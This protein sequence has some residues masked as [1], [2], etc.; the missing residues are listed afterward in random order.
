[1]SQQEL[2]G[3][4][5]VSQPMISIWENG[6]AEPSRDTIQKISAILSVDFEKGLEAP[7]LGEWVRK[8]REEK[9]WSRNELAEKAGISPLTIYFIETGK[10]ESPQ[11]TTLSALQKALGKLPS[12]LEEEVRE[13]REIEQLEFLGPFPVDGWE[14]NVGEGKIPCIY[15]FYDQLVRPVRI[16][17]TDDLRRRM[18]EYQRDYWWFRTPTVETFAYV[19][20]SDEQFRHKTE[21]VMIKL[22]GEHAIFNIQEKL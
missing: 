18:K 22:V 4:L 16:G 15:V 1:M 13:E 8:T 2:A 3:K 12:H 10:T 14:E 5:G 11:D 21:K 7:P 6:D 17:E 9:G 20:V 19:V